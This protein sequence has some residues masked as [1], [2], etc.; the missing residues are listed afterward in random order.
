MKKKNSP[1]NTQKD[2]E[3]S[4][5][6][7]AEKAAD[8]VINKMEM[9]AILALYYFDYLPFQADDEMYYCLLEKEYI[10]EEMFLTDKGKKE[11]KKFDGT[12]NRLLRSRP[13]SLQYMLK[14]PKDVDDQEYSAGNK[15]EVE[16]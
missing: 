15:S 7:E 1:L 9:V 6:L 13:T 4:G 12:L 10:N 2:T 5:S 16:E 14:D 3:K 8:T 11:A